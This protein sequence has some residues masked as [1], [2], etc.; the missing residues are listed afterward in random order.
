M[1]KVK[2]YCA[3]GIAILLLVSSLCVPASANSAQTHWEGVD[4]AGAIVRDGGSPIIVEKEL[5][6]FDI[7]EFPDN[8][9]FDLDSYLAYSGKVTA[10]YTFFN[11]AD[12]TVTATLLFPFGCEPMYATNEYYGKDTEKYDILIDSQPVEKVMRYTLSSGFDQFELETDLALLHDDYVTDSFY[13]LDLPVTKYV[14]MPSGVDTD[15]YGAADAGFDMV[16]DDPERRIYFVDQNSL[17]TQDDGDL[18][19]HTGVE[20]GEAITVYVIGQDYAEFPQWKFYQDG[21]VED[22]EEIDGTMALESREELSFRDLALSKWS[23]DSGV[24]EIDWYNAIVAM[25]TGSSDSTGSNL[26]LWEFG[27]FDLSRYLMRW[28]EYEISIGPGERIVNTVT[29]PIYPSINGRYEPPI[30]EYTYLLSPAKTWA[31][32]GNLDIVVNTPYYMTVSGPEGFRYNN[33]G[34]ELHL[35]GLPEGELT[36]ILCAEK[37]PKAPSAIGYVYPEVLLIGAAAL[38]AIAVVLVFARRGGKRHRGDDA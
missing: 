15:T 25:L 28:Y 26:H 34:Y 20:N 13:A 30:Y 36:F 19:V 31:E 5:L 23:A 29:A 9:Y 10:E 24:S 21:G 2:N 8:H 33:P 17:H 38:M 6:T 22:G 1:K 27:S 37:N 3:T 4:S 32:F 14:F 12:Y 18:R 11:P 35:T 16:R 7:Q